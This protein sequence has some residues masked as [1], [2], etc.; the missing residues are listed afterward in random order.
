MPEPDPIELFPQTLN[1]AGV[2]YF[3]N[4]N[5]SENGSKTGRFLVL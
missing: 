4:E 5:G 1:Q 2:R 3:E